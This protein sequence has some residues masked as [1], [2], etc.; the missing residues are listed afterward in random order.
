MSTTHHHSRQIQW[1]LYFVE[2]HYTH[3]ITTKNGSQDAISMRD[4]AIGI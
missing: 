1:G 4:G 3:T 2:I